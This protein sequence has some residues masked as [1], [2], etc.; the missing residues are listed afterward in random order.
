MS[1]KN[2][3]ILVVDDEPEARDLLL[4]LLE[5]A[6]GVELAGTAEGV[7]EAFEQIVSKNPDLVL[8]DI[9]MP[10]KN[11]FELVRMVHEEGLDT[12]FI[13][14][15]AYEEYAIEA[16]RSS[17]FDYLLKPVDLAELQK[18]ISRFKDQF[19][20]NDIRHQLGKI[21]QVLAR[22]SRIKVNTRTGFIL[23]NPEEVVHCC[24]AGNYTEVHLVNRRK[25]ILTSNLGKFME[26]LPPGKFFRISRSGMININY[27]IRVDHKAGTCRLKGDPEIELK[28]AR[29][30]RY[31]LDKS[32]F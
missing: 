22:E 21:L 20:G 27:L 24:A 25:E 10:V 6:G 16:I 13:F 28:V 29:Q 31:E 7:D 2:I 30:R 5:H 17:A 15:T 14:V 32:F 26:L 19:K 12:G 11:G 4:T 9:Q 1:G 23:I 8:L 3:S 18:T